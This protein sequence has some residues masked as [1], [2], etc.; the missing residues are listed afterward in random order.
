L[1]LSAGW[2]GENCSGDVDECSS[3]PCQNGSACVDGVDAYSCDCVFGWEGEHCEIEI[4]VCDRS[5][6][7]CADA[8]T[9]SHTDLDLAVLALPT[10]HTIAAVR[11][12][13]VHTRGSVLARI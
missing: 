6:D 13:A 5:E 10:K 3:Y 4:L 7:D 9:C 1:C 8:A 11:I 12:H 2:E